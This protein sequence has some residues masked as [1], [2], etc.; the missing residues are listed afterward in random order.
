VG[1]VEENVGRRKPNF[2]IFR[3]IILALFTLGR[4]TYTSPKREEKPY[5]ISPTGRFPEGETVYFMYP[6]L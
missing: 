2:G 6:E 1:D 5:L 4:Q 3:F